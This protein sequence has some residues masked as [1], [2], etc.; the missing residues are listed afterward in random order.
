MTFCVAYP[1][2]GKEDWLHE[3]VSDILDLFVCKS[4]EVG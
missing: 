2:W 1:L 4:L 3:V